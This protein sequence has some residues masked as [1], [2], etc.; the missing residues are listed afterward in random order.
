MMLEIFLDCI[1]PANHEFEVLTNR[2]FR[3]ARDLPSL[4][5]SLLGLSSGREDSSA[6]GWAYGI[7]PTRSHGRPSKMPEFEGLGHQVGGREKWEW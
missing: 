2:K 4:G 1:F 6:P 5:F 3:V 7:R